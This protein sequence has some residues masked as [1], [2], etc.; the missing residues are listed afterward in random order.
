RRR[1][2]DAL[3]S[4]VS[5]TGA[6]TAELHAGDRARMRRLAQVGPE[7]RLLNGLRD[8][9]NEMGTPQLVTRL[10]DP[11]QGPPWAPRPFRTLQRRGV[12]AGAAIDAGSGLDSWTRL[13]D[14]LR[15]TWDREDRERSAASFPLTPEREQR[16]LEP[17]EFRARVELA[18][19]R[20]RRDGLRFELHRLDFPEPLE[21]WA[22]FRDPILT[23]VRDT[24]GLTQPHPRVVVLLATGEPEAFTQ[25]RRR[26]LAVWEGAWRES[27]LAAPAAAFVDRSVGLAGIEDIEA[28]GTA[29]DVWL[30]EDGPLA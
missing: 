19:E 13:L 14:D 24:D 12:L 30:A 17:A 6:G 21:P 10:H 16:W 15:A 20:H 4:L 8:L 5:S 27:G 2:E 1:L 7:D 23:Q 11:G 18:V 28:F 3:K 25:L 29:A 26:L 22:H 9:A